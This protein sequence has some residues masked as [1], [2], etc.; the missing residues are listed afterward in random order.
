MDDNVSE[1][2][3]IPKTPPLRI[4]RRTPRA[5]SKIKCSGNRPCERCA[6]RRDSCIFPSDEPH[7]SI[8][9]RY[10][11]DLQRRVSQLQSTEGQQGQQPPQK[12]N[13][14]ET[15]LSMSLGDTPEAPVMPQAMADQ[16][17][18]N[19]DQ[20]QPITDQSFA[21]TEQLQPIT[22]QPF[23]NTEQSQPIT[24]PFA[25]VVQ[26]SAT[27]AAAPPTPISLRRASQGQPQP[28]SQ[29]QQRRVD[30]SATDTLPQY[31]PLVSPTLSY[32]REIGGRP[33]YLGPT[34][35][36]SFCRRALSLLEGHI[37]SPSGLTAP[38]NTDGTAFRLVWE[39][40][41]AVDVSD[42]KVLPPK[43]YALHLYNTCRFHFGELFGIVDEASFFVHFEAFHKDGLR[44]AQRERLWFCSYLLLMAF[45]KA[46]LASSH[47]SFATRAM[48]LLPDP[49]HMHDAGIPGIEL[50]ALVA[51]YFQS[52]DMRSTCYQYIGQAL[53]LAFLEG[54]HTHVP[55]DVVSPAF[56]SRCN[57]LWWT[58][59]VLDQEMS[60]NNGCPNAI[61]EGAATLDLPSDRW[62]TLSA[63]ALTLRIRLSKLT[64]SLC[65]TVYS[66]DVS[67]QSFF[68]PNTA[69]FLLQL[70]EVSREL[71]QLM[72]GFSNSLQ[73]DLPQSLRHIAMSYQHCIILATR[74]LVMWLLIQ[75]LQPVSS[76]QPTGPVAALLQTST[77]SAMSIILMLRALAEQDMLECFL[78]FQLEYAFSAAMLLSLTKA[79][80]PDYVP[81]MHWSRSV[82]II[83]DQMITKNN[84]VAR[85]RKI[86]MQELD[87]KLAAVHKLHFPAPESLPTQS[88]AHTQNDTRSHI[89]TGLYTD[90]DVLN[91]QA[92]DQDL[93]SD[94]LQQTWDIDFAGMDDALFNNHDQMLDLAEQFQ[95]GD[96]DPS[97]IFGLG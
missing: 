19:A 82:H 97:I 70:A 38:L 16:S 39:P 89:A 29:P 31:N 35:T 23:A 85:L 58:V 84:V 92:F 5:A 95:T 76:Q 47:I 49:T 78:P 72:S 10:L 15:E 96:M 3:E 69:S 11:R 24:E 7:V 27:A 18:S 44:V 94:D 65:G 45:G 73:G 88:I 67:L 33:R 22:D 81:D 26:D 87:A 34:S 46:F 6:R 42:L 90:K 41:A 30:S 59:Y 12:D 66:N 25:A 63:K 37:P 8:P 53:R 14:E 17:L 50:L 55:D 43:D 1:P 79:I 60:A 68:I 64:A 83:F 4:P 28:Q 2:L 32:V 20:P 62:P 93:A 77:E 36:W 71:D 57:M 13:G 40:K 52:I 86:E 51:L 75:N 91:P 56:A 21:N 54:I 61:P 48:A 80:L 9:E 74:P